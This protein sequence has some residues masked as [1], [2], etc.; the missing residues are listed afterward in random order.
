M[1]R[2]Q[3]LTGKKF[4]RLV[5]VE[6][7][8]KKPTRWLCKCDCGNYKTVTTMNLNS[9][10]TASCGCLSV[11]RV[12]EACITHGRTNSKEHK[13]WFCVK[14]RCYYEGHSAYE[15][16]GGRGI[17]MSDRLCNNFEAFYEEIG[18]YPKDGKKYSVERID[19]SLGY[20]EGNIMWVEAEKQ[21]RNKNKRQDNTSGYTGVNW[22]FNYKTK[23]KLCA[24]A[25]WYEDGVKKGKSFS[26]NKYGLLPAFA[27]ACKY[28]EDK[29]TELNAL[30]YGYTENHGK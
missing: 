21:A 16:Y 7:V 19:N 29:I 23:K 20:I 4:G 10:H 1:G 26:A 27:M 24:V 3:D 12:K 13:A 5:A 25:T 14:Q 17:V 8:S 15:Y 28:R 2:L 11:D 18:E 9:G 6:I 22:T 30:G